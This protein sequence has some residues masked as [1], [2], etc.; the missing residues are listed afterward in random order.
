MVRERLSRV[1]RTRAAA[2]C[3]VE[4][5]CRY[6]VLILSAK[7]FVHRASNLSKKF[8]VHCTKNLAPNTTHL[9]PLD[10]LVPERKVRATLLLQVKRVLL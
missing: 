10:S 2:R 8:I 6:D 4:A 1:R 7:R 9:C 3:W 5:H